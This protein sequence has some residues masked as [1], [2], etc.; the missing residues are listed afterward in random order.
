MLCL[1]PAMRGPPHAG[2]DGTQEFEDVGHTD[3]AR[4]QMAGFLV[5][6]VSGDAKGGKAKKGPVGGAAPASGGLGRFLF[7]AAV[8]IGA[9]IYKLFFAVKK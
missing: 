1:P 4:D 9:I 7:P 6:T 5:G 8:I 2:Q 3:A